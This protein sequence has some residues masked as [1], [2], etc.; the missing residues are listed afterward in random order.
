[1]IYDFYILEKKGTCIFHQTF[2]VIDKKKVE[3]DLISGFFSAMLLFSKEITDKRLEI[4][5]LENVR[6]IFREESYKDMDYIFVAFVDENESTAQIQEILE[7]IADKFFQNYG[8]MLENWNRNT[9]IFSGFEKQIELIIIKADIDRFMLIEK[10]EEIIQ[11]KEKSR[12]EGISIFNDKGDLMISNMELDSDLKTFLT[13]SIELQWKTGIKVART[14]FSYKQKFL[15]LEPITDR[16]I[17]AILLK[18]DLSIRLATFL[19]N[20]LLGILRTKIAASDQ[21]FQ[22]I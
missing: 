8:T 5:E 22:L 10:L 14:I 21:D 9:E 19:V 16:L 7:K 13:K 15:F 4:L 6:L 12:L 2:S 18:P 11:I 3:A 17:A 1:M 20:N